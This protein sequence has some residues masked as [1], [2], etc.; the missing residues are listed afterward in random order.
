MFFDCRCLVCDDL[1]P[2]PVCARCESRLLPARSHEPVRARFLLNDDLRQVL[3]ALKYRRE[4]R[5]A[6][7]AARQIAPL[8]PGDPDAICWVPATPERLRW[9]GYDQSA[10]IARLVARSLAV[11]ARRLLGRSRHDTRQ[12]GRNRQE[13][14]SGPR[15][16]ARSTPPSLVVL[17][18]D[19][20]TTG[21][22]LAAAER[23]LI[24][25]GADR[26]IPVVLAAAPLRTQLGPADRSK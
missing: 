10:E 19:V 18:D 13:R 25:A 3:V 22:T 8:L 20:T 14:T 16:W 24:D 15:L 2:D 23:T 4:R 5:V 26:V 21:S 17:I 9:R 6:A 11:P 7:W 1:D 12:T